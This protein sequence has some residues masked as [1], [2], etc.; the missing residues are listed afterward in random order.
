MNN[1]ENN[2]KAYVKAISTLDD[3]NS[4]RKDLDKALSNK[5]IYNGCN[6]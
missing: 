3:T 5:H 1:N 2:N 6:R 4:T